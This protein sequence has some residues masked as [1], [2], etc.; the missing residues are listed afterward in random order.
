MRVALGIALV[1]AV[2]GA[3]W[4]WQSGHYAESTAWAVEQQRAFQNELARLVMAARRGEPGVTGGLVLASALYGFVHAAGPGHGK[5]LIGSAGLAGRGRARTMAGLAVVSAL[6][7]GVVAVLLVYCGLGLLA[8]GA[9]WAVETTDEVLTPLSYAVIAAIGLVLVWRGGRTLARFLRPMPVMPLRHPFHHTVGDARRHTSACGC[10]H[11]HG[12]TAEEVARVRGWR[13]GLALVAAIAVRPC[14]GA[15]MVLVIAWQT[16]LHALGVG[17]VLAMALGTGA[18]TAAVALGSVAFREAS[19]TVS[20]GA[21]RLAVV[22]PAL[23]LA[24]GAVV[25]AFSLGLLSSS[26]GWSGT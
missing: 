18:F 11:R 14:T 7:Q 5:F 3:L 22:A 8:L 12:P 13:D 17:A 21:A 23:Q 10:G 2:A 4:F 16:G 9:G 26:L 15:V 20:G 6:A 19:F 24:A 1:A 25:L